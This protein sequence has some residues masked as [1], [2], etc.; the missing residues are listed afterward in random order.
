MRSLRWLE[1]S[2]A[3]TINAPIRDDTEREKKVSQKLKRWYVPAIQSENTVMVTMKKIEN[4]K[5]LP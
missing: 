2:A 3:S 4:K 5:K 1:Y